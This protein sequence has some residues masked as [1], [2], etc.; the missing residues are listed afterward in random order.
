MLGEMQREINAM[1]REIN[2]MIY[3]TYKYIFPPRS[4]MSI[5]STMLATFEKRGWIAQVKKNG[6]NSVIFVSPEREVFAKGRHNN[7]HK[8]WEFDDNTRKPFI[9][10]PGKNWWVFNAELLHSKTKNVKNT[11][12]I[13]DVLV[14]DGKYLVGT[15]YL[16]R[17]DI[18]LETFK[19]FKH[20]WGYK[21][22]DDSTF[23][24]HNMTNDFIGAFKSLNTDEDEGLM[25]KNPSGLLTL[26]SGTN[27]S[28]M[29]KCRRGHKNFGF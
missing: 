28:W 2:A 14:A 8:L 15:T 18:L 26:Q 10:L 27:A 6:T 17:F 29:V 3:D 22:I 20:E 25:L 12:Y 1:Q 19:S 7:D 13:F 9:K 24:A 23:L 4:N 11:N 5:P 21:A 16:Q